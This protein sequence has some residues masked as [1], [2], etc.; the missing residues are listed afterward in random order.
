MQLNESEWR[1]VY[2]ENIASLIGRARLLGNR[3]MSEE[4]AND[5]LLTA[6]KNAKSRADIKS[7][8]NTTLR[9]R[10]VDSHRREEGIRTAKRRHVSYAQGVQIQRSAFQAPKIRQPEEQVITRETID[11]AWT[12]LTDRER[13]IVAAD[14]AGLTREETAEWLG[15]TNGKLKSAMHYARTRL[16]KKGIGPH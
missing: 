3:E 2:D 12:V 6:V 15:L 1:E 4:V 13:K 11:E 14:N 8:L 10:S 9:S 7:F 16:R 5:A